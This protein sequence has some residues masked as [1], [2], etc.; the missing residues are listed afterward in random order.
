MALPISSGRVFLNEMDPSDR[1]LVLRLPLADEFEIRAASEECTGFGLQE[2]LRHT[3]DRQPVR[4]GGDDRSHV[5]GFAVDRD[6]SGPRQRRPP[7]LARFGERSPVLRH[8]FARESAQDARR[9][10]LLGEGIV[11]QDRRLACIGT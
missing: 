5:G 8:L 9:Q 7:P 2:Q 1:H 10:Y 4:I 6:L 3:A 11:L